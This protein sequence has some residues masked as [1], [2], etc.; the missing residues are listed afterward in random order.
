MDTYLAEQ[1]CIWIFNPPHATHMGGAWERMIGIARKNLDSMFL[2]QGN[3]MVSHKTLITLMAEVAA[4]INARTLVPVSTDPDDP[5][6][7]TPATLLTQK[8]G[9]P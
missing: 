2:Q 1:G 5:L 4:I 6:L 9:I 3:L 7:L 8:V